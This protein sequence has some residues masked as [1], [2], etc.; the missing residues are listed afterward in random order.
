MMRIGNV[1]FPKEGLQMV[2]YLPRDNLE[3]NKGGKL[4]AT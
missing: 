4:N 2:L 1:H 3:K